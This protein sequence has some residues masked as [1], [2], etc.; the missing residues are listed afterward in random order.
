VST[1]AQGLLV[2]LLAIGATIAVAGRLGSEVE[3][4]NS[5]TILLGGQ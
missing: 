5:Y 3:S 4:L 1:P 2:V